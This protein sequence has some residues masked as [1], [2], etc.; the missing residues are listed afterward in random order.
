[1]RGYPGLCQ[2]MKRITLK[3][4]G[5]GNRAP[6]GGVDVESMK[7]AVSLAT[8][9]AKATSPNNQSPPPP[10]PI[11]PA[12]K[13]Q[14]EAMASLPAMPGMGPK[15]GSKS[16]MMMPNVAATVASK[17]STGNSIFAAQLS[18]P[19]SQSNVMGSNNLAAVQLLRHNPSAMQQLSQLIQ[20]AHGKDPQPQHQ[21]QQ[22]NL[23]S[24]LQSGIP[25][26]AASSTQDLIALLLQ[27]KQQQETETRNS[28]ILHHLQQQQQLKAISNASPTTAASVWSQLLQPPKQ[29][30]QASR[31]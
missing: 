14:Q 6:M 19:K 17:S 11:S 29:Q 26:P 16:S 5:R 1:M 4:T 12:T 8:A 27:K 18:L 28:I 23:A 7:A 2:S 20:Q 31:R 24:L 3:G 9:A 10:S 21:P 13:A 25:T 30:A 15:T 22:Q